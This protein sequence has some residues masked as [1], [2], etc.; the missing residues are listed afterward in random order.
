MN[1]VINF[2]HITTIVLLSSVCGQHPLNPP[3]DRLVF[4]ESHVSTPVI[5]NAISYDFWLHFWTE[6]EIVVGAHEDG[7]DA[8]KT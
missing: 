7:F 3:V 1:M 5:I 2:V 4:A 6:D 8:L